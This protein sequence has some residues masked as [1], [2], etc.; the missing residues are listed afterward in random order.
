MFK[1]DEC[2]GVVMKDGEEW[3]QLQMINVI[4]PITVPEG[5]IDLGGLNLPA[6]VGNFLSIHVNDMEVPVS[7]DILVN[8]VE[9]YQ[10]GNKHTWTSIFDE[11]SASGVTIP[12]GGKLTLLIKKSVFPQE[13]QDAM[14]QGATAKVK[15]EVKIDNPI[16]I[17]VE[18]ELAHIGEDFDSANT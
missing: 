4:S 17:E 12:V 11:G 8:S 5:K 6:D 7:E 13:V 14:T 18:A 15:V 3:V 1:K 16:S 10:G 9:L 2:L